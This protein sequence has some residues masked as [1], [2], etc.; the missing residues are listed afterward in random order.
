MKLTLQARE[1]GLIRVECEG[2]INNMQQRVHADGDP[3]EKLIGTDGFG[4]NVLMSLERTDYIDSSGISWLLISHKHFMPQ[5]GKLVLHS[6]P[7]IVADVLNLLR[8]GSILHIAKDE[9]EARRMV[10]GDKA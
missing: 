9:T 2:K 6:I 4:S 8:M 5:G 1:A 3:L 7:P 10:Q